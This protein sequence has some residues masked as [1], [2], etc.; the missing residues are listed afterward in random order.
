V[1]LIVTDGECVNVGYV[2]VAVGA[3]GIPVLTAVVITFW[4]LCHSDRL[5][6]DVFTDTNVYPKLVP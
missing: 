2:P 1:P 4:P 6:D 3:E 5:S